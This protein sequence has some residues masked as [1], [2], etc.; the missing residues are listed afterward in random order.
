MVPQKRWYISRRP[1]TTIRCLQRLFWKFFLKCL[2][3][4]CIGTNKK[5]SV[6]CLD[7]PDLPKFYIYI[8]FISDAIFNAVYM[9]TRVRIMPLIEYSPHVS[10]QAARADGWLLG[11]KAVRGIVGPASALWDFRSGQWRTPGLGVVGN[12]TSL[13]RGKLAPGFAKLR[14]NATNGNRTQG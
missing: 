7:A 1:K 9:Y 6:N 12:R 11:D 13:T 2:Q 5:K 8:I 4:V 10:S 14:V 3:R